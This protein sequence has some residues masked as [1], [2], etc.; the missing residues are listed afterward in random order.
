MKIILLCFL[1]SSLSAYAHSGGVDEHGCHSKNGARHCHGANT[2]KYIP[3]KETSRI[4]K[5]HGQTCSTPDGEGRY[6]SMD[7][8]GKRCNKR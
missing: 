6:P 3:E 1:M 4:K 8:Y 7:L 5:L 2:G